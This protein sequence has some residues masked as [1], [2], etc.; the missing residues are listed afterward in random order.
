MGEGREG[1]WW[2]M[3]DIGFSFSRRYMD[4]G[5]KEVDFESG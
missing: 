4:G 2:V 1:R 5:G 3:L